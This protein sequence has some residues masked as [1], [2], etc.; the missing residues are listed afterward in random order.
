MTIQ[1]SAAAAQNVGV[2]FARD[3]SATAT[4]TSPQNPIHS[5]RQYM[6]ELELD[7]RQPGWDAE[8][9]VPV[10]AQAWRRARVYVETGF[11]Q[12]ASLPIPDVSASGDGYVHLVWFSNGRRAV[13]E[14]DADR[15]H[16]TVLSSGAPVIE[17]DIDLGDSY[18]KLRKFLQ[19]E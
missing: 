9:G 10:T 15:A 16:W 13:V 11:Q 5:L 19:G 7:T 14:V 1:G 8:R 17:E 2:G 18:N 4:A 12:I 6:L 3:A